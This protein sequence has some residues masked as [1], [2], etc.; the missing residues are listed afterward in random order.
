MDPSGR[1]AKITKKNLLIFLVLTFCIF[2]ITA[3]EIDNLIGKYYCDAGYFEINSDSISLFFGDSE[4]V[5]VLLNEKAEYS[6]SNGFIKFST[7]S[8][9]GYFL[10]APDIIVFLF[11]NR[12][13]GYIGWKTGMKQP[14]EG[15][16]RPTLISAGV[17]S[18]SSA[19]QEAINGKT[20]KYQPDDRLDFITL[21][22]VPQNAIGSEII[23]TIPTIN[24]SDGKDIE[25]IYLLNGF[26]D[27]NRP[28]LY[29]KNSRIKKIKIEING[30]KLIS[31]LEDNTKIK[32]VKLP[33]TVT[34]FQK[35][36]NYK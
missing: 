9:S 23:I 21:P 17:N 33:L 30:K 20:L 32:Y 29:N 18:V 26:F 14:V 24:W 4:T 12:E 16:T 25:G 1:G 15:S 27:F 2:Q 11:K 7:K 28:D 34:G 13:S 22:W 19:L 5:P 3:N 8:F 35:L 6:I 36:L 31:E 10:I